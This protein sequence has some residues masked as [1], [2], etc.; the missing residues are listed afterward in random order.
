MFEGNKCSRLSDNTP[1]E[2][3]D[4]PASPFTGENHEDNVNATVLNCS[5][6]LP[7]LIRIIPHDAYAEQKLR[8]P[9]ESD[10]SS[11]FLWDFKEDGACQP[12]SISHAESENISFSKPQTCDPEHTRDFTAENIASDRRKML[13]E[14]AASPNTSDPSKSENSDPDAACYSQGNKVT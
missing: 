6:L 9:C 14:T 8:V 3:N 12:Q 7:P 10:E 2:T 4:E 11:S 5:D 13:Q 1:E